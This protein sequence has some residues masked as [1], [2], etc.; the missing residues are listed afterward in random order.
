M[1]NLFVRS[2]R[3]PLGRSAAYAGR[4]CL[5]PFESGGHVQGLHLVA[6]LDCSARHRIGRLSPLGCC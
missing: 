3:A 5:G 2:L 1:Y 6:S 4:N